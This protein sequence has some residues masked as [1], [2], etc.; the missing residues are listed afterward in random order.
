MHLQRLYLIV[1][2]SCLIFSNT[3]CS[4]NQSTSEKLIAPQINAFKK[5]QNSIRLF[6]LDVHGQWHNADENQN[7]QYVTKIAGLR[8]ESD[9]RLQYQI[10]TSLAG[11][12]DWLEGD[13]EFRSG[14]DVQYRVSV[15]NQSWSKWMQNGKIAGTT[16][17]KK[18]L[19]NIQFQIVQ[20]RFQSDPVF[21]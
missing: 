2:L 14:I 5:K 3:A 4:Q 12:S 18:T 1:L 17:D 9:F 11:W 7:S 16:V 20:K 8:L 19:T 15:D 10:F 13:D 21:K 6:L